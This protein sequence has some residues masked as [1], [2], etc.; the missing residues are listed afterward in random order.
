MCELAVFESGDGTTCLCLRA[1][2][3]LCAPC[4]VST[5]LISPV[6]VPCACVTGP[7]AELSGQGRV[8]FLAATLRPET[9]YGQTNFWLLPKGE[10]GAYRG[11]NNEIYIM[12][13]RSALNLS[14][15]E[16]MPVCEYACKGEGMQKGFDV[17]W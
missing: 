15:Q 2:L 8:F 5:D 4:C 13:D 12:S 17:D 9:M 16:R 10:Y 3:A 6:L 1:V 11:L 7:L 14:F